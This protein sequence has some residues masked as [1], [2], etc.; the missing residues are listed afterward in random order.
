MTMELF[1]QAFNSLKLACQI[2]GVVTSAFV[3]MGVSIVFKSD[4]ETWLSF[5]IHSFLN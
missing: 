2:W 4:V 1:R 5:M 3:F